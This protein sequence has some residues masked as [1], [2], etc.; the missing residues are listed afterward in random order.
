MVRKKITLYRYMPESVLDAV[1]EFDIEEVNLY[2][3]KIIGTPVHIINQ[4][5]GEGFAVTI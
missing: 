1:K 2:N 3:L 5:D 4:G